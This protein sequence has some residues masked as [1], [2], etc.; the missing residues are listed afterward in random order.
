MNKASISLDAAAL[1]PPRRERLH[2]PITGVSR[3]AET[4]VERYLSRYV[5]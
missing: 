2:G 4:P 3:L 5:S 1:R